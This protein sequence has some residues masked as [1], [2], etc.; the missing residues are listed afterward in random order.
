MAKSA[1]TKP[2]ASLW[3]PTGVQAAKIALS[4]FGLGCLWI[5]GS[6][7]LLHHLVHDETLAAWLEIIKGWL[8]VSVTAA[9]LGLVLHRYFREIRRAARHLQEEITALKQAELALKQTEQNYREIF[10]ATN[11]AIFLHDAQ[12]GAVLD[13]NDT[14]LR[15]YGYASKA[16]FL[17]DPIQDSSPLYSI[18]EAKRRIQLAAAQGPQVFEWLARKK[19][20]AEFWAEVSLRGSQIGGQARV[21]AV[22][23]DV[24]SRKQMEQALR[25]SEMKF[26]QAFANNPAAIA[27]TRLADRV[28]LEINDTWVT[29][30]GFRRDEVVGHSARHLW[31]NQDAAELLLQELRQH[32]VVRD[33]E[34][35][36]RKKT[37]EFFT[38]QF[39][40]QI[41]ELESQP[42]ILA[43][44]V[45]V[46]ARKQ[47]ENT[48]RERENQLR[49]FV[50]HSPAAIAMV[51]KNMR[52]LV[53]SHRWIADYHLK[54]HNLI[55]RSH[56]EIFPEIPQRWKEVH[57]RC[58]A[59][60]TEKCESDALRRADGQVDWVRWEIRP[61]R[62]ATGVVGGLILFSELLTAR[63][64][65]EAAIRELNR[66][67]DQRVQARTAELRA[68]N[69]EL[70]SFAYAVSHDLRAPLRA[71]NGFSQALLEDFGPQLPQSARDY[72]G[73]IQSSS[74]QMSELIHGLLRLSR[75]MRASLQ[76]ATVD[77]SRLATRIL[78][79]LQQAEPR[80]AM[81][82]TVQPGLVASGDERLLEVVLT[83]LLGNAWKY[84]A[85]TPE[86]HIQVRGH[87]PTFVVA[88]N[89]AGFD[90]QHAAKLFQ[91]FQRLHREDEFPGVGIGL[92]TV[93]RI[94]RRHGGEISAVATPGAGATFS[95]TLPASAS[96]D[97][98]APIPAPPAD[99][100]LRA[101]ER[102]ENQEY[103]RAKNPVH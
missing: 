59:G 14:M 67:L 5:L 33:R 73:L 1:P 69:E 2:E 78:N 94:I 71:M 90:M 87:A 26:S 37:G 54:E 76:R 101:A 42:V 15:M 75:S 20:G 52:Y 47:A 85:R 35:E 38:V 88:D 60:A 49:L 24:S 48:L 95:F 97:P 77:L 44:L 21:L 9:L 27:L 23:R 72:L 51:D 32:G 11:E 81:T 84:T 31:L 91:P 39:S 63:M 93:Q 43:T 50:E 25:L 80:P 18:A 58:L 86:P 6:G 28:V 55:G 61:W 10:N 64:R 98:Q 56:Y 74:R 83:N 40:A 41:L 79:D 53:V 3:M 65:A 29:L 30:F 70:D 62:T 45:D 17:A 4:Y 8:F 89:G 57:R 34:Q 19:N 96:P 99:D 103:G 66:T 82:W 16:E 46:T 92:A 12:T 102:R 22:I 7:W 36:F 13:V 100:P 68:S